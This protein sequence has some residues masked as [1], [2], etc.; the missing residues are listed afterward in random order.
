[1][2]KKPLFFLVLLSVTFSTVS[3]SE[4]VERQEGDFTVYERVEDSKDDNVVSWEQPAQ[5]VGAS[6]V[7][8]AGGNPDEMFKQAL[9]EYL[10]KKKYK[11]VHIKFIK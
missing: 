8:F 11:A 5:N 4:I 2:R 6:T 9:D 7:T 10:A 3:R 1:M